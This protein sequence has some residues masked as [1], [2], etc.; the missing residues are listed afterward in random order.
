V[1]ATSDGS[2]VAA[3]YKYGPYGEP[4]SWPGSRFRY[5]GQIALPEAS[6]Y[7]YKARVYDPIMG[8]FLQ[9]DP[10][11]YKD[12]LNLYSYA[13][14]DPLTRVDP[15]GELAT[16]YHFAI[17][18]LAAENTGHSD[19][20]SLKY[21]W[22]SAAI[23]F[24]K[25]SQATDAAHTAAHAMAGKD[26]SGKFQTR[27]QAQEANAKFVQ[28]SIKAG[29]LG[30]AGHGV[31]DRGGAHD[32]SPWQGF[33]A[34]PYGALFK[35]FLRDWFPKVSTVRDAYRGTKGVM[36]TPAKPQLN[37]QYGP[38]DKIRPMVPFRPSDG[39]WSIDGGLLWGG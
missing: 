10:I 4:E 24:R 28:D 32:F 18:F 39:G 20:D 30:D 21:A 19:W 8:R 1:I 36:T 27:E 9:T 17:T 34:T 35:H 33:H 3:A 12:D 37:I 22:Q 26:S 16:P 15:S 13:L 25:D 6:L 38:S 23:D 5:T 11:G 31:Q 2:G 29:R 14:D 7:Y